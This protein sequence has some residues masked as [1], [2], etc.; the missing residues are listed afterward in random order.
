MYVD[1]LF[2]PTKAIPIIF[3]GVTSITKLYKYG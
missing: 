3:E 2:L 1:V